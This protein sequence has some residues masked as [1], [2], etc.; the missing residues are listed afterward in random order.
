MTCLLVGCWHPYRVCSLLGFPSALLLALSVRN[1]CLLLRI[2]LLNSDDVCD[3][4]AVWL[5]PQLMRVV[6]KGRQASNKKGFRSSFSSLWE[7]ANEG[8]IH[9]AAR[10]LLLVRQVR[11]S[12]R[13]HPVGRSSSPSST[14]STFWPQVPF[15]DTVGKECHV[16]DHCLELLPRRRF[17]AFAAQFFLLVIG[18]DH[19]LCVWGLRRRWWT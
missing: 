2:W 7:C 11:A 19:G 10:K 14:P 1:L 12:S 15:R 3:V 4:D 9:A 5:A 13:T 6:A 18:M 16:H 8:S 17:R